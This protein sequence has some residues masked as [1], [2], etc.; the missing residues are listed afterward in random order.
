MKNFTRKQRLYHDIL[1][2]A[3]VIFVFLAL[4]GAIYS[5]VIISDWLLR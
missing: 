1:T 4:V 3:I 2:L 5:G